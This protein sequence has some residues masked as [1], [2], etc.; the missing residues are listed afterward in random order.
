MCQSLYVLLY[1]IKYFWNIK[2][3]WT[4]FHASISRVKQKC[5]DFKVTNPVTQST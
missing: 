4:T 1:I 5:H 2:I 3:F